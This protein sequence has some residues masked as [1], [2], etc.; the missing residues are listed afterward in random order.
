MSTGENRKSPRVNAPHVLVKISSRDRFR[1]SYLKDLSEGG[2]FVKTDKAMPQGSE[3]VIDLLPPGWTE[4]LRLRGVVVRADKTPG[5][6]GMAVRFEGNEEPQLEALRALLNDYQ[7]GGSP[8]EVR[9][10]DAQEQLQSVLR[11][12]AELK[13]ALEKREDEFSSERS[14][15]E[16]ASKRA[17]MLQAEL[18]STKAG[19]SDE[20]ST[21]DSIKVRLKEVEA[22]LATSQ[23]E[24]ME[25]RTRLAEVDGEIDA[26][27]HEIETLEQDDSTSRR[28][29]SSL[30]KEKAEL[31]TENA[32]L[33]QQLGE[34][35][36]KAKELGRLSEEQAASLESLRQTERVQSEKLDVLA[37]EVEELRQRTSNL[38][39]RG[40]SL[41]AECN[42]LKHTLEEERMSF[43]TTLEHERDQ[44]A[45]ALEAEVSQ[46]RT[47]LE[48]EREQAQQALESERNSA[49]VLGER[50]R[51]FAKAAIERTDAM[52]LTLR[53]ELAE[54]TRRLKTAEAAAKTA[55][56]RAER[57]KTKERELREL[58][59]MVTS[60]SQ[61]P[62]AAAALTEDDE[63]LHE[64]E[65]PA[66]VMAPPL[67]I[68]PSRVTMAA[69]MSE[70]AQSPPPA[71][72]EDE[73]DTGMQV[74]PPHS[75]PIESEI[76][77]EEVPH[78]MASGSFSFVSSES[79]MQGISENAPADL[80]LDVD[81]DVD[82]DEPESV[83]DAPPGMDKPEFE[84]R[85]KSEALVKTPSFDSH[86]PKDE[87]ERSVMGLL[88]AGERLKELMV[89]GRGV[90]A[91]NEL[92]DALYALQCAGAIRFEEPKQ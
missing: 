12:V 23:H 13:N 11:Q 86:E 45:R 40:N 55:V 77:S 27:K 48:S 47:T 50:E 16:E 78:S 24:E 25:L 67:A 6:A 59:S 35:K 60:K 66:P 65:A 79:D 74:E 30:A 70:A 81:V 63:V 62:E 82:V 14:K 73:M 22:E 3:L 37:S 7:A 8:L 29:A 72:I 32:K 51:A 54:V 44:A 85:V 57:S 43:K 88:Q 76:A 15:R 46:A 71:P 68:S 64:E 41:D 87:R 21:G 69:A 28:L 80:E 49:K 10:E 75:A 26:F 4:A 1:S 56:A 9:P 91:P 83:A 2:L 53:A 89:L 58:M 34:T 18:E 92:V 90:V 38:E 61:S 39:S 5:N 84:K 19:G 36:T 31:T 33:T 20:R 42:A 52:L 17:V